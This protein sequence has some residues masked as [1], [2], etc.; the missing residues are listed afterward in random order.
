MKL[1]II[2]AADDELIEVFVECVLNT[3]SGNH[4]VFAKIMSSLYRNYKSCLRNLASMK[5]CL[6]AKRSF[7]PRMA[8]FLTLIRSFLSGV[9]GNLFS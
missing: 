4:K 2:R 8:R 3:L 9:V 6:K 5:I 7:W 1:Q